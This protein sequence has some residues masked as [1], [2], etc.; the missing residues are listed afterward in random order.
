[1]GEPRRLSMA[2]KALQSV[3]RRKH[4]IWTF[5]TVQWDGVNGCIC[6]RLAAAQ[7]AIVCFCPAVLNA[8]GAA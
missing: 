3:A 6:V 5:Q 4:R 7:I 2:L 1:M 8:C